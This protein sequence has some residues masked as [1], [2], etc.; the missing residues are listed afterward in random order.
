[1]T[2]KKATVA[3]GAVAMSVALAN[4]FVSEAN[5]GSFGYMC[6][7]G[8]EYCMDE[9]GTV[10]SEDREVQRLFPGDTCTNH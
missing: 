8:M 5:S 9:S 1:M 10:W 3:A 2:L 7:P 6:C 4:A